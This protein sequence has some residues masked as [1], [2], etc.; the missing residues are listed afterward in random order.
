MERERL[1]EIV[2]P[3]IR[4]GGTWR[5]RAEHAIDALSAAGVLG[6]VPGEKVTVDR[7]DLRRCVEAARRWCEDVRVSPVPEWLGNLTAELGGDGGTRP[8][9]TQGVTDGG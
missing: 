1:V 8:K 7:G 6:G 2:L 5:A 9:G 4:G 3:H